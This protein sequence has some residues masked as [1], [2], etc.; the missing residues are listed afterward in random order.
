C[1]RRES[2]SYFGTALDFW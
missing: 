2:D 1:A